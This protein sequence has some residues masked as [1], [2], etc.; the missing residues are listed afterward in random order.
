[1]PGVTASRIAVTGSTRVA[2]RAGTKPEIIV[3][4]R[5]T[6][7]PVITV[8]GVI[9]IPVAP[10][11]IPA[12][13]RIAARPGATRTP[14]STPTIDASRP[15]KN[16]SISTE[17]STCRREAP[18]TRSSANSFVRCATVTVNVLKIRKPPTSSATPANTSSAVRRNAERVRE[19]LGLLL[20]R[21]LARPDQEVLARAWTGSPP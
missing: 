15:T 12:A 10:R 4:T 11:S 14:N 18:S 8:P 3:A 20:G 6:T 5:P 7:R 19:V 9:T 13:L 21:L 2:R 16:V 17:R 1:M